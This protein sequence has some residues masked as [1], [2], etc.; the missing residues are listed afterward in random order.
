MFEG[1]LSPALLGLFSCSG[2]FIPSKYLVEYFRRKYKFISRFSDHCT[3][4]ITETSDVAKD[5]I[6]VLWVAPSTG[7]GCVQFKATVLEEG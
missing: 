4:T 7:H 1:Q 3:N 2:T 6:Q 5:E